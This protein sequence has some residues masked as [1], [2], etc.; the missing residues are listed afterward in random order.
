MNSPDVAIEP[1]I[2]PDAETSYKALRRAI[3][4]GVGFSLLFVRCTPIKGEEIVERIKE[5]LPQKRI[6]VLNLDANT[7]NLYHLVENLTEEQSFDV[8]FIRG[9]EES[10]FQYE[11][12]EQLGILD[13]SKGTGYGG[14]WESI[15]RIL[16]HL[17]LS[18]ERFRDNF[19]L[20]FVFLLPDFALNYFIRRA[21]DFFDWRSNVYEFPTERELVSR[22]SYHLAYLDG[23]Y[24]EYC[25]QLPE[26][27]IA[28]LAKIKSYLEEDLDYKE[29]SSLWYEKGLIHAAANEYEE[30]INS[31][32]YAL[33]IRSDYPE[34]C[35]S[36][37]NALVNLGRYQEAI[38]AYDRALAI[39]S[40]YNEAWQNR[41]IALANLGKNEKAIIS[42]DRALA[43][44]PKDHKVLYSRG[45]ALFNLG[46]HEE[47]IIFYDK[48]LDI[49][50]DNHQIWNNRGNA[51]F[52]LGRYE[53]AIES[54]NKA[55]E[56]KPNDY[57][58]LC[59]RSNTLFN[60]GR[61]EEAIE[62]YDKALEIKPDDYKI[63]FKQGVLLRN[64]GRY[65]EAIEFYD[66]ALEIKPDDQETWYNRVITLGI[67]G[68]YEEASKAY[69]QFKDIKT[70]DNYYLNHLQFI[71]GTSEGELAAYGKDEF[72]WRLTMLREFRERDYILRTRVRRRT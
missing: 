58:V 9:L 7:E 8:L 28:K 46:R 63:L 20:C 27:R 33:S 21:P 56:I 50:T 44:S 40:D 30:A 51:L 35:N 42:Y 62:S 3:Q 53:E 10:L 18:R 68:R 67:S 72:F 25:E 24:Q 23:S 66:K 38:R 70:N 17:N 36:R 59:D 19:K 55:L 45:N 15:P 34:A 37:G 4:R 52:H 71:L 57:K 65:E 5:D 11:D 69:N 60:L 48:A 6:E 2:H 47:S 64:L 16:G 22:E 54:Y 39:N 26:Q 14:N 1:D 41:G 49:K 43:I 61:Y 32:D 13:R 12:R 31:Y 29:R